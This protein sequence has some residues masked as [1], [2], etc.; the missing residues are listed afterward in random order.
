[1]VQPIKNRKKNNGELHTQQQDPEDIV[2]SKDKK[3]A[4]SRVIVFDDLMTEA[5]SNH[6]NKATMNLLTTKLSHHNNVSILIVCH[7]LY[8]K[9]KN[10]VLLCDQ[11]TGVHLHAITNQQ[12]IRHYIYGFLSDDAKKCQ[13]HH[14]FNEHVLRV[15]NSL[16]GNRR[17]SIF[18]CF[19]PGLCTDHFGT[20]RGIGRFLTFN[21]CDF[22]IMHET[23]DH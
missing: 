22:S 18:I 16:K 21:E 11:L 15:N 13:F 2:F 6:E 10:S 17:G 19:T 1:M 9:G 8:R 20:H 5:F 12:R 4:P 3:S 7:E 23:F 14:L